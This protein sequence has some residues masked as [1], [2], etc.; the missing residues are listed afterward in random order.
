MVNTILLSTT[1][2]NW[3]CEMYSTPNTE[4]NHRPKYFIFQRDYFQFEKGI[5]S[6]S[7]KS[8]HIEKIKK[9]KI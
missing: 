5:Y 9:K 4:K 6:L 8:L 2:K 1:K 3:L 7:K